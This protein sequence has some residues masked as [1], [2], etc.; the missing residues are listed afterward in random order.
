MSPVEIENN[1]AAELGVWLSGIESFL[2]AGHHSF[3]DIRS[4]KAAPDSS[5]EF[6]LVH[7]TLQR[8]AMLNAR[9]LSGCGPDTAADAAVIGG[10]TARELTDLSTVLRDAMLLSEG[11]IHSN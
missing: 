5:K 11:L 10:I 1:I 4:T 9:L 7:S 2:V 3:A 8:C 6:R